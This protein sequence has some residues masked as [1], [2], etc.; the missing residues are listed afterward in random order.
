MGM[1]GHGGNSAVLTPLEHSMFQQLDGG[2]RAQPRQ[3]GHP[4]L[5]QPT[6]QVSFQPSGS[7]VHGY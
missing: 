3:L 1:F 2:S 5:P 6:A 4:A 7:C